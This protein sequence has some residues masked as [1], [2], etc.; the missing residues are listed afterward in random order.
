MYRR[1]AKKRASL[2]FQLGPSCPPNTRAQQCTKVGTSN[3]KNGRTDGICTMHALLPTAKA[4]YLVA[5]LNS[6]S[7]ANVGSIMVTGR[8][9]ME[10]VFHRFLR[11]TWAPNSGLSPQH[12]CPLGAALD[13]THTGWL[14]RRIN[15]G[16]HVDRRVFS[17]MP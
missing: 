11:T 6:N 9:K 3:V 1:S 12:Q 13:V 16:R 4:S 14:L 2:D 17:T 5:C 8:S 7:N 15:G 10:K